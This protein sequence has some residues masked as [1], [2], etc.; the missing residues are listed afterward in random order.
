[1][2]YKEET[3]RLTQE[4]S[5]WEL[6]LLVLPVNP[7]HLIPPLTSKT[8]NIDLPVILRKLSVDR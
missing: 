6:L 8:S 3:L 7:T 2:H 4:Q 1:M 5:D